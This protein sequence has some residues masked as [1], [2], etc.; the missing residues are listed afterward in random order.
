MRTIFILFFFT[1]HLFAYD[2]IELLNKE[3]K[4]K[5]IELYADSNALQNSAILERYYEGVFESPPQK[6]Y[7]F[8]F[9]KKIYW[10]AFEL[11]SSKKSNYLRLHRNTTDNAVLY[12]YQGRQLLNIQKNGSLIP[13]KDREI[14][15]IPIIFDLGKSVEKKLFL[16]R[17]ESD[18]AVVASFMIGTLDEIKKGFDKEFYLF[19]FFSG[20]IFLWILYNLMLFFSTKEKN[21]L[22]YTLYIIGSYFL[23]YFILGYSISGNGMFLEFILSFVL[24]AAQL[25]LIGLV[26]F[27]NR[28]LDLY[29]SPKIAKFNIYLVI[30][31]CILFFLLQYTSF[32][33][34][35]LPIVIYLL[36]LYYAI[37][38][39][40]RYFYPA[41]FYLIA[42]GVALI[43]YI[44]FMVMIDIGGVI[45]YSL[46]T[47]HLPL[48]GL[49]WD[50]FFL[51]LAISYKLKILQN[52]KEE[53][54]K[55]LLIK[56][57][58]DSIGQLNANII[59]QWKTPLSEIGSISSNLL[60]KIKYDTIEKEDIIDS[61]ELIERTLREI[62][63]TTD[64]FY[65][66]YCHKNGY[67]TLVA[68]TIHEVY[69]LFFDSLKESGI[70]LHTKIDR[71]IKTQ[72]NQNTI[73]QILVILLT[74][75]KE[76]FAKKDYSKK[77]ITISLFL[78]DDNT[79]ISVEDDAGGINST[80]IESI[81]EPYITTKEQSSGLGLYIAEKLA[82]QSNIEINVKNKGNGALFLLRFKSLPPF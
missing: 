4:I 74:N 7:S 51:S 48:F 28:F 2:L 59:H 33:T 29:H 8:G 31:T 30:I 23:M 24:I 76:Q 56:S 69:H 66:Q 52:E 15:E 73:F 65:Q 49:V 27:T 71:S 16:L 20:V 57:N 68:T 13:V 54:K 53:Y 12:T 75:A 39:L 55:M 36:F 67:P 81:F 43:S 21:Y 80:P 1:L 5:S 17:L 61:L 18:S 37:L 79:Y 60:A 6:A 64:S 26:L 42:T 34:I 46:F 40:K 41:L 44:L 72:A 63:R 77:T 58:I 62:A 19:I 9:R 32:I 45:E 35:L 47:L 25:K 11:S 50:I 82:E 3:I 78:E 22:Y 14:K 70:V 38:G 10:F